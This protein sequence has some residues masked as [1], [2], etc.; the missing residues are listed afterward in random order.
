MRKPRAAATTIMTAALASGLPS[1]KWTNRSHTTHA[2]LTTHAKWEIA[3]ESQGEARALTTALESVG[4]LEPCCLPKEWSTQTNQANPSVLS[5]GTC[6]KRSGLSK[7][8]EREE[9]K[10]KETKNKAGPGRVGPSS[11]QRSRGEVFHG[12]YPAP[13]RDLHALVPLCA[14]YISSSPPTRCTARYPP[15]PK[16]VWWYCGVRIFSGSSGLWNIPGA[17]SRAC[18]SDGGQPK[19]KKKKR[20][21]KAML[22][23][24]P[25]NFKLLFSSSRCTLAHPPVQMTH[26]TPAAS[27]FVCGA[28]EAKRREECV[29]SAS[30]RHLLSRTFLYQA[31]WLSDGLDT[32]DFSHRFILCLDFP[33]T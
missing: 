24:G 20:R 1:Q 33:P 17:S 26:S 10:K 32:L 2:T 25:T 30:C 29:A 14:T 16:V 31:G 3:R 23:P 18:L 19:K 12:F 15:T 8:R 11:G 7:E 28:D 13:L 6:L 5:S 21:K 22:R 9:K 4:R 27:S